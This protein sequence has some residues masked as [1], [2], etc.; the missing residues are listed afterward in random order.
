MRTPPN[1]VFANQVLDAG[2]NTSIRQHVVNTSITEVRRADRVAV[3]PCGQR[4][5]QQ[6]IEVAAD[7]GY[8][9]VIEDPNTGHVTVAIKRR[10]LLRSQSRGMLGSRR[11]KPQI[12]VQV[13]QLFV[14]RGEPGCA[15]RLHHSASVSLSP[16]STYR[17]LTKSN[18]KTMFSPQGPACFFSVLSPGNHV[19][20]GELP[21]W[22]ID[23]EDARPPLEPAKP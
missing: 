2:H 7:A 14:A 15:Q 23:T 4:P 1:H 10:N 6:F 17:P 16:G 18:A 3:A 19:R 22:A 13:A 12:A 11:M 21:G 5:G 9:L 20:R 8:L